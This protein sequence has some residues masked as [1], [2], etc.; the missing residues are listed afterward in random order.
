MRETAPWAVYGLVLVCMLA[1]VA[2]VIFALLSHAGVADWVWSN[3]AVGDWV[4]GPLA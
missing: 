2:W 1:V 4:E 3:S